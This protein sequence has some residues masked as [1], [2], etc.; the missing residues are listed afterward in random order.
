MRPADYAIAA[1]M[2]SIAAGIA[3]AMFAPHFDAQAYERDEFARVS[4]QSFEPPEEEPAPEPVP[5][6]V[7]DEEHAFAEEP[8]IAYESEPEPVWEP[9]WEEYEPEFENEPETPQE[10][11]E[12]PQTASEQVEERMNPES[13]RDAGVTVQ[14]GTRFTWYSSL[15]P[16]G[17]VDAECEAGEDGI[18]R[19]SDG[20][21]VV[22]SCDYGRGE[23][24][25]TPLGDGKVY[26]YCPTSGTVDVYTEW[27]G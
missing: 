25:E 6:I 9:V 23:V 21:V 22:A 15:E 11:P 24:V 12:M 2:A 26:D 13:F 5:E 4:E 3:L 20:Y 1:A 27:S 18:F 8:P 14:G 10:E 16:G 17:E 7:E 19:D